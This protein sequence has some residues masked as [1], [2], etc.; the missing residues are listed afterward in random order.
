MACKDDT[1]VIT[2]TFQ[3]HIVKSNQKPISI[4]LGEINDGGYIFAAGVAIYG[5]RAYVCDFSESKVQVFSLDG[6]YI[7]SIPIEGKPYGITA[8]DNC[9]YITSS[10]LKIWKYSPEEIGR[11]VQ[12]EC[13]DR[14]RMPSSA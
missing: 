4:K 8:S 5:D 12:Q 3:I 9:L 13:R 14:S 7:T 2:E 10:G 6:Q 11:A 1:F